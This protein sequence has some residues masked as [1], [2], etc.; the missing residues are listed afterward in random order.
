MHLRA[1]HGFRCLVN[2]RIAAPPLLRASGF[3]SV[4]PIAESRPYLARL[5]E[6]MLRDRANIEANRLTISR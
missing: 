6:A 2:V 1:A 5:C 4:A 3:E